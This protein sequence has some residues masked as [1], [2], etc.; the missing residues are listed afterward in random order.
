MPRAMDLT[1][2][3]FGRLT[4]ES[5][6]ENDRSG[7]SAWL[8]RCDCGKTTIARGSH[9]K[10][11][12]I[13]SCGCIAKE[14]L[15]ERSTKHGLEHTRTYRIWKDMLSRCYNPKNNRYHRY[16][17]RGITVCPEWKDNIQNF[18][19][20]AMQNGYR[21][22]LTIDRINNEGPYSPE[23][24]RWVTHKEQLNNTS[25]NRRVTING[26]TKTVAQWSE[27]TGT[28]RRTIEYR[29]DHG[30]PPEKAVKEPVK[31]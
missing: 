26:I 27:E 5:R 14:R 18:H 3:R 30:W 21:D 23:N 15:K 1:G 29:L 31:R 2:Q 4:V 24:C 22:D 12:Y 6:A 11:G 25:R 9:L 10:E 20:W 13:Q 28:N 8:C 17:G 19:N 16:G 7:H